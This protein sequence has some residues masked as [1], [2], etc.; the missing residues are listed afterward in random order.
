MLQRSFDKVLVNYKKILGSGLGLAKPWVISAGNNSANI[1]L[2]IQQLNIPDY[3]KV[4]YQN[5]ISSSYHIAGYGQSFEEAL[6]RVMGET[7]ERYS[8]MSVYHLLKHK[9]VT[10]SFSKLKENNLVLPL[11]FIN[12]GSYTDP[13]FSHISE[14]SST[15]WM[16]LKNLIDNKNMYIPFSLI[17]SKKE[18]KAN[19][20]PAMS[21]GTATHMSQEKALINALT[22]S[23]QLHAFMEMW[24]TNK[25]LNQISWERY[26]SKNF[27]TVFNKTFLK[28]NSYDIIVLENSFQ[29]TEFK[30]F[31]VI[32]KNKRGRFPYC[33]VGI[34]GGLNYE[35]AL[36]RA[37]MEA[38]AIF[39][40]LQ[41][42]YLF[43]YEEINKINLEDVKKS[44]N[45]DDTF[46]FWGNY[47]NIKEKEEKLSKIM[48]GKIIPFKGNEKINANE[49]LTLL[50][51]IAC[52][53]LKYLYAIDITPPEIQKYGYETIRVIAPE[54]LPMCFP[55]FPYI[56]HEIFIKNGVYQENVFP[57]PLP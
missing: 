1:K 50:L 28:N 30:N 2:Y 12:L 29:D 25:P 42:F 9:L 56:N 14:D 36:L 22:E 55:A 46:L 33:A 5:N 3:H 19:I 44:Y 6:T 32:L 23:Y 18:I 57:H 40:N 53:K 10:N 45:L 7:I 24:F 13:F 15:D 26:V 39:V 54:L 38:A 37:M 17:G 35:Y 20:V 51:Q 27:L 43:R 41:E 48:S 8:F 31:V 49:E 52:K 21:T 16:L 11:D 47:N 34:Q 4:M